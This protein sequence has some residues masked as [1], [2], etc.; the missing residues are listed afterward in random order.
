LEPFYGVVIESAKNL[1]KGAVCT[2]IVKT[3]T[4]QVGDTIY[5]QDGQKTKIR[6]LMNF[7]GE[8]VRKVLP[9]DPAEILGFA[10]AV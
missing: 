7:K 4:L 2:V 9:G 3:G 5:S 10:K 1:K 8:N 6:A